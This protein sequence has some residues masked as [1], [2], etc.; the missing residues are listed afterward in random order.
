VHGTEWD[1]K[2]VDVSYRWELLSHD[3][4]AW[5]VVNKLVFLGLQMIVFP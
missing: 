5:L 1:R 4:H 3:M 2:Y